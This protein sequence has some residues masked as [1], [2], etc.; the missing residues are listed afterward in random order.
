MEVPHE[1]HS[2]ASHLVRKQRQ[3]HGRQRSVRRQD[4]QLHRSLRQIR[5]SAMA[6]SLIPF[7]VLPLVD[8]RFVKIRQS[9]GLIILL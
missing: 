8:C 6:S 9:R 5:H 7:V 1:R 4:V 2:R 3:L